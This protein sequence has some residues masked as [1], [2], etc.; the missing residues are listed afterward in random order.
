MGY[1]MKK[2][3]AYIMV[4]VASL[5]VLALVS[6]AL[7][8]TVTS[9]NTT[10][11]YENYFGLYDLAV[12]GNEQMFY[13]LEENFLEHRASAIFLSQENGTS[14][15]NEITKILRNVLDENF[16]LVYF[17]YHL[18]KWELS[19]EISN[20]RDDFRAATTVHSER[21]GGFYI[22]TRI[23]KLVNGTPG[24]ETVVRSRINFLDDYTIEMVELTRI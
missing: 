12:A 21:N 5:A 11:R 8:I 16:E 9:R 7:T 22:E 10:A 15:A 2:G 13:F 14:F 18:H 24:H 17:E 6:A 3:N 20:S 1:K 4:V 23:R 19:V